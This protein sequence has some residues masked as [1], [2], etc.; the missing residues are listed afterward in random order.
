VASIGCIWCVFNAT[1]HGSF[2]SAF[3]RTNV[4]AAAASACL[5]HHIN[6]GCDD[7]TFQ[8]L[9]RE[10]FPF[11]SCVVVVAYSLFTSCGEEGAASAPKT[12]FICADINN[13]L[14]RLAA[15]ATLLHVL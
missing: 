13:N 5:K 3:T 2:K 6:A 8:I 4:V 9:S 1:L 12:S 14:A 15:T 7:A 11:P 10:T